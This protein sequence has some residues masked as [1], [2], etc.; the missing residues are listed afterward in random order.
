MVTVPDT[1]WDVWWIWE[2]NFCRVF[3]ISGLDV[4][5]GMKTS[6]RIVDRSDSCCWGPGLGNGF[7]ISVT[8]WV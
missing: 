4:S 8:Y 3:L 7:Y 2:M 6:C 1:C 5:R